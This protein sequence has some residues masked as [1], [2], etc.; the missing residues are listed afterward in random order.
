MP[1]HPSAEALLN[2]DPAPRSNGRSQ[3]R[4]ARTKLNKKSAVSFSPFVTSNAAGM[5]KK[6]HLV[7]TVLCLL[8]LT[9][10]TASCMFAQLPSMHQASCGD[11]PAHTPLSQDTPV[12]CTNHQ[13]PFAATN[14]TEVEQPYIAQAL[15]PLSFN[16]PIHFTTLPAAQLSETP[17]IPLLIALRI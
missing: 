7:V 6:L 4:V 16:P 3:P 14:S 5:K 10:S 13:Q 1:A 11:C 9:V 8:L 2:C 17:P 12:C 15:T